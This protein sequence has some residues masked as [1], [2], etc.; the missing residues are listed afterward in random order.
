MWRR[1]VWRWGKSIGGSDEVP[2]K[3]TS[4]DSDRRQVTINNDEKCATMS[5]GTT[6]EAEAWWRKEEEYRGGV[7]C[8]ERPDRRERAARDTV[9][10]RYRRELGN[11]GARGVHYS[12][13]CAQAQK[14][15]SRLA[16]TL[17]SAE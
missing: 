14:A 10:L 13:G 2:T 9:Y 6:R 1:H 11:N 16:P 7:G 12:D 3:K 8:G 17:T 5:N 15:V 4:D